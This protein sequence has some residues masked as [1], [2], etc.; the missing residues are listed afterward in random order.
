MHTHPSNRAI[1]MLIL[2][3][4]S[5]Q[6]AVKDYRG[7]SELKIRERKIPLSLALNSSL[8]LILWLF[9]KCC[10]PKHLCF[11]L[12]V[13][14]YSCSTEQINN[15]PFNLKLSLSTSIH[16]FSFVSS[17]RKKSLL[18]ML[19]QCENTPKLWTQEDEKSSVQIRPPPQKK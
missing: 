9:N 10:V 12:F 17:R 1:H 2:L 14:N 4:P 15:T 11:L 18:C 5:A 6:F 13:M 7:I 16:S 19:D 3:L 8:L